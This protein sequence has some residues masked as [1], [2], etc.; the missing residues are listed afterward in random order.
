MERLTT[1]DVEVD[2][3]LVYEGEEYD[4]CGFV[5]E[6]HYEVDGEDAPPSWGYYGGDPGSRAAWLVYHAKLAEQDQID[7]YNAEAAQEG[8]APLPWQQGDDL[9]DDL[10]PE[11]QR[12]VE[13]AV[14]S[15]DRN[16]EPEFE[17]CDYDEDPR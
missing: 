12:R 2:L 6:V 7:A 1:K 13:E 4:L 11:Q 9:W 5:F 17:P 3:T 15:E 10:T 14:E 16:Y 8:Y